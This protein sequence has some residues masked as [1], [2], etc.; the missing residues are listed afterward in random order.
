M[1]DYHGGNKGRDHVNTKE[2]RPGLEESTV[3][4][5]VRSNHTKKKTDGQ[6]R[7]ANNDR[8]Q[9]VLWLVSALG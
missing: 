5:L 7:G 9:P 8:D 6:K 1:S 2:G 4:V 3:P